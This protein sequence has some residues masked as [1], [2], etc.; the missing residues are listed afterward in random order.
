MDGSTIH[1]NRTANGDSCGG[2][3]AFAGD[4]GHGAGVYNANT[5]GLNNSTVS[6]NITGDGGASMGGPGDGGDGGGMYNAGTLIVD[7][8]TISGNIAGHGGNVIY[9]GSA[10]DGGDGGG[11]YNAGTLTTDNGAIA[12][13][14]TIEVRNTILAGN[15]SAHAGPDCSGILTSVG[16]NLVQA[17]SGCTIAG[18]TTGNIVGMDPLLHPLADNGGPTWTHA[19]AP[20]SLAVDAGSCTGIDGAAI[21][22]DQRGIGRPQGVT[23]DVGAYEAPVFP[24]VYLPFVSR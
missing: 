24:K 23:C 2:S 3:H 16:Y 8:G 9:Q 12:I 14:V 20:G 4:G 5:L 7:N 21:T 11:M 17:V 18:N 6:G 10:G 15:S 13:A 1:G 19:L 22:V